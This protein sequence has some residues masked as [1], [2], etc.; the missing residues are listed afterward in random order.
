M[1]YHASSNYG[2]QSEEKI[3]KSP[4][5]Y[6]QWIECL[7]IVQKG[8]MDE[9]V[10]QAMKN[11]HLEWQIGVAERFIKSLVETVN[12]RMNK[13]LDSFQK[14][15]SRNATESLISNSLLSLRKECAFLIELVNL[16]TIP[17][18]IRKQYKDMVIGEIKNIQ[19]NLE[20]SAKSDR[21]GRLLYLIKHNSLTN[22]N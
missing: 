22:L 21:T 1:G 8:G 17:E 20:E 7:S 9:E 5:T 18:N 14:I 15:S 16:P 2:P 13:A 6:A 10:L 4:Q 11:G 3:M 19:N 12:L